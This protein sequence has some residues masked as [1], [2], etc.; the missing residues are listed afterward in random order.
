VTAI[1][2]RLQRRNRALSR[3]VLRAS[4]AIVAPPS[5]SAAGPCA[6][7]SSALGYCPR[8]CE[9]GLNRAP[10]HPPVTRGPWP[11]AP[12]AMRSIGAPRW[13][14][15]ARIAVAGA[16]GEHLLRTGYVADSF[17]QNT[18]MINFQLGSAKLCPHCASGICTEKPEF[19][20][21]LGFDPNMLIFAIPVSIRGTHHFR[22]S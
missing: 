4:S 17:I 6:A 11:G 10:H 14:I 19:D 7:R 20:Q 9:C 3:A 2:S 22:G 16:K 5:I 13:P 21:W 15:G 12:A 8:R 18:N 1:P